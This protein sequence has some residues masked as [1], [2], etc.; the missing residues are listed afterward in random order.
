MTLAKLLHLSIR[1]CVHRILFCTIIIHVWA[2]G[3]AGV[4]NIHAS[5]HLQNSIPLGN[6]CIIAATLLFLYVS[7]NQAL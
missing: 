1:H 7:S 6:L 3:R 2:H 4:N 5:S